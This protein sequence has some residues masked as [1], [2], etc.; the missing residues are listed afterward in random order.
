[1]SDDTLAQAEEAEKQRSNL[2]GGSRIARDQVEQSLRNVQIQTLPW[3]RTSGPSVRAQGAS[4]Q[5]VPSGRSH[6]A[7]LLG[8]TAGQPGAIGGGVWQR[9][10]SGDPPLQMHDVAP[11]LQPQIPMLKQTSPF[12]GAVVGHAPDGGSRQKFLADGTGRGSGTGI[13][14]QLVPLHMADRRHVGAGSSP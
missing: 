12:A 8:T 10:P 7:P 9:Q 2:G 4:G 11:N 5:A 13:T 14:L 6:G 1:M 3:H